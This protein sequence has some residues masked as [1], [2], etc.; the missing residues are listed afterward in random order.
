ML[1]ARITGIA[2]HVP[3]RIVTNH[4]LAAIMDTSDEWIVERTGIR[5]RRFVEGDVGSSDLG[6]EAARKALADAGRTARDV[7]FVIFATTTP[8]WGF[9]GNGVLVQQQ[10]G[11]ADVGALDVRNAC[12][13]FVYAL[14]V[15]DAFARIGQY[16]CVLV[17]GAE[18]QSTGLDMTTRGRDM[19]VLF[20]DGGGAAV[21]EPC[22][23]GRGVLAW[24]LHSE[25]AHARELWGEAPTSRVPGRIT[26]Q[27]MA[28][29][30]HYPRMNGRQVFK[31]ATTRFP[32][33]IREVLAAAGHTLDDV[34]LI[35]PHQANRRIGDAVAERLGLPPE[36]VFQNIDRYGNTTAATIPLATQSALDAGKLH[37][38]DLILFA[39]VGAG[40]TVGANLWRWGY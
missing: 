6:I 32:E 30:R 39:A 33:V 29:G 36:K 14:S 8:D 24:A 1:R 20:G 9:P 10:L 12:S 15:A 3:P 22:S 25:G 19:A 18:V 16:Q 21:V 17:I 34:A 4:D 35:V 27:M 5:E 31:H 37:K 40:F 26:A 28:E 23:H 2:F 11:L 13:G 7:D 38:G